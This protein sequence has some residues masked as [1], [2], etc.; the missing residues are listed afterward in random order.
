MADRAEGDLGKR[1]VQSPNFRLL[2]FWT[3]IDITAI[4][5]I[6]LRWMGYSYKRNS[7]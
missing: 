4:S 7:T 1:R 2:D 6:K 3:T 5:R